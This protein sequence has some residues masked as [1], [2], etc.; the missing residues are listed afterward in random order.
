MFLRYLLTLLLVGCG[1]TAT[2]DSPITPTPQPLASPPAMNEV[3]SPVVGPDDVSPK[4]VPTRPPKYIP[5]ARLFLN[6]PAPNEAECEVHAPGTDADGFKT[7]NIL[8][9]DDP[10]YPEYVPLLLRTFQEI[11]QNPPTEEEQ[12][13]I[14]YLTDCLQ[15]LPQ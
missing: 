12:A 13:R 7:I 2:P 9:P 1:A 4:D 11:A 10:E 6:S 3:A 5:E 15:R 14:T 8:V